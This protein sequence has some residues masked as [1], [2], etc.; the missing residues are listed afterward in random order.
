MFSFGTIP[1]IPCLVQTGYVVIV[2]SPMVAPFEN[3]IE[4]VGTSQA[5]DFCNPS[6]VIKSLFSVNSE[7]RYKPK[8]SVVF[9]IKTPHLLQ[10]CIT[11]LGDT[12]IIYYI[13]RKYCDVIRC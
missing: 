11:F 7:N 5:D 13:C 9:Y 8:Q 12:T 10:H 2:I 4:C 3:R 6:S 1:N